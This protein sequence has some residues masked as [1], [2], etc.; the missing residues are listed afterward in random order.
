MLFKQFLDDDL[1]CASYLVGDEQD[2]VAL[3]VDPA[4]AIEQ[5]LEEAEHRHVRIDRVLENLPDQSI[6]AG[7]LAFAGLLCLEEDGFIR[8]ASDRCTSPTARP[9]STWSPPDGS[10]CART[11]VRSA[12]RR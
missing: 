7:V 6:V 2:G 12:P 11:S 9:S 3:V 8:L 5:Y 1:G 10:C 4:Y